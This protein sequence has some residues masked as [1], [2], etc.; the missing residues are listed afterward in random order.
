MENKSYYLG[1]DNKVI[2]L[3][4]RDF[5]DGK[6]THRSF[7]NK[8]GLL[9]AYAPWCGFCKRLK[10]DLI[11]LGN[12][13]HKNGFQVAALN[14]DI[15]K[16]LSRTIG[17]RGYPSLYMIN[18]DGSLTEATPSSRSIEDIL[19]YICEYTNNYSENSSGKCCR[20]DGNNIIC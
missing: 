3:S 17:V 11:F 1:N 15:Y 14:C 18:P 9:K 4:D 19:K 10:D 7:K 2:E 20:R 13:L 5:N 16:E 6:V 12:G 8:F